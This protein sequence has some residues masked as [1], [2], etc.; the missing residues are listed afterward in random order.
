MKKISR[1][2]QTDK[3]LRMLMRKFDIKPGEPMPNPGE[4]VIIRHKI[5]HETMN[6]RFLQHYGLDRCAVLP[7]KRIEGENW[8]DWEVYGRAK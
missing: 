4:T 2:P 3:P 7:S 1:G 6:A 8:N 5:T